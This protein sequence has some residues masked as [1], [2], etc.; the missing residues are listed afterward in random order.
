MDVCEPGHYLNTSSNPHKCTKCPRGTFQ[1]LRNRQTSCT[2][3]S[4]VLCPR[5]DEVEICT[6]E[7][8]TFCVCGNGTCLKYPS[9]SF[10]SKTSG[11]YDN[12]H[13]KNDMFT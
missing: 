7:R 6:S 1:A 11:M 2:K 5:V 9:N 12:D 8:D 10:C 4:Q 3:C 13:I